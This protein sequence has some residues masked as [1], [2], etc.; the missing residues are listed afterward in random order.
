MTKD[1]AKAVEADRKISLNELDE[2]RGGLN[3]QPLPPRWGEPGMRFLN[4]QP[5]PP[6]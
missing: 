1:N 6:G 3:P 5:L 2:V 4:P